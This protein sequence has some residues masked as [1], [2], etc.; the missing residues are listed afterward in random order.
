MRPRITHSQQQ[1][2]VTPA[3]GSEVYTIQG[4]RDIFFYRRVEAVLKTQAVAKQKQTSI[5]LLLNGVLFCRFE[6][7]GS[8]RYIY[9]PSKDKKSSPALKE[10]FRSKGISVN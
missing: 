4:H 1:A 3:F 10:L 9:D 6:S 7:N 2:G 8:Y 5:T